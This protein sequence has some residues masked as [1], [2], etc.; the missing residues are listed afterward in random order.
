AY[1]EQRW[2]HD[3]CRDFASQCRGI[4]VVGTQQARNVGFMSNNANEDFSSKCRLINVVNTQQALK[5]CQSW[6]SL[7]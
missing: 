3:F 1:S 5:C 2:I 7:P 4:N 6:E